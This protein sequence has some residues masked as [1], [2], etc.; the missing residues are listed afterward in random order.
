M[1]ISKNLLLKQEYKFERDPKT[2]GSGVSNPRLALEIET[3]P[4]KDLARYHMYYWYEKEVSPDPDKTIRLA[5]E[6]FFSN[7]LT[8]KDLKKIEK[9]KAEERAKINKD[10]ETRKPQFEWIIKK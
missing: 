2:V 6:K 8:D 5:L 9:I 10:H 3:Y 1:Q 4:G 7:H